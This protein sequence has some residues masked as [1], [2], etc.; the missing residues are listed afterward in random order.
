M[1]ELRP[2]QI[3]LATDGCETL[4]RKK[5]VYFA[6]EVR[7][8]KTVTALETAKLFGAKKVLFLTKK[9]AIKSI[10]DDYNNFGYKFDLLVWNDE[11]LHK[12]LLIDFDLVIHD[13][14]H[15]FGAYP[16]P[17]VTAKLFKEKF[18][19]LPMIFLSGT[20]TPESHSQWYH[21]FWVSNNSPF[22]DFANFYKWANEYVDIELKYLGYA[23]VKDYSKAR[24]KD[25]WHR[26]RY[27]IHTFTQVEAGFSTSVHENVL[28]CPMDAITYKIVDK[29]KTDLVVTN[30]EGQMI[31]GDTAVKL[32][33]KIHQLFSGTCKF[34]DGTSKVIDYSKALFI[35]NHFKGEKIA[36]FYKYKEE[37][38]AL[39]NI[40]GNDL[41]DNLEEFNESNKNIALQVVSGSEGIS[42]SKAKYLVYYNI[43]FSSRLYWQ[44][45]DRLTTMQR[46]SNDVYWV[47]AEGGIEE[48]I[49]SSVMKKK[50]YTTDL[51]KRDY[52][53]KNSKQN[54]S[55]ANS[56]RMA[57]RK[58]D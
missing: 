6:M 5:I 50:D 7:T 35:Q 40:F 8:G 22:N 9:K 37:W 33:Q 56:R 15:R 23:Q 32:Q 10:Q 57:L 28:K 46:K 3:K 55:Q 19:D 58:A 14:H 26:I 24:K 47:F 41:T 30:K 1:H 29:L 48:K 18:G 27:Y 17:N 53:I 34:E 52:G 45:R 11:S 12:L 2:Y 20:P 42:L 21:Q 25:F 16:K 38:N 51:F 13:E 39:K 43:D 36:I 44:S 4:Q 54:N 31:L 49:Y